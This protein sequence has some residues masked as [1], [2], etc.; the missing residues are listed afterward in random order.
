MSSI[1]S[2]ESSRI[3]TP[4]LADAKPS[5][6]IQQ[7]LFA[8]I[9]VLA[10]RLKSVQEEVSQLATST[11]ASFANTEAL[12]TNHEGHISEVS[13]SLAE[14]KSE[15]EAEQSRLSQHFEEALQQD[16]LVASEAQENIRSQA[17]A[18]SDSLRKLL[19]AEAEKQGTSLRDACDRISKAEKGLVD[20]NG[21]VEALNDR[22]IDMLKGQVLMKSG[23]EKTSAAIVDLNAVTKRLNQEQQQIYSRLASRTEALDSELRS[24]QLDFKVASKR[25]RESNEEFQAANAT[26]AERLGKRLEI[27]EREFHGYTEEQALKDFE[28]DLQHQK[29]QNN[30]EVSSEEQKALLERRLSQVEA[31]GGG[32]IQNLEQELERMTELSDQRNKVMKDNIQDLSDGI[33]SITGNV[34]RIHVEQDS[35]GQRLQSLELRASDLESGQD[36]LKTLAAEAGR[37]IKDIDAREQATAD[38]L[39]ILQDEKRATD[40]QV[41]ESLRAVSDRVQ[42]LENDLESTKQ[43]VAMNTASSKQAHDYF[44]GLSNGVREYHKQFVTEDDVQSLPKMGSALPTLVTTDT[45][46]PASAKSK[47][48]ENAW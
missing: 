27:I 9:D 21:L 39:V 19:E 48:R 15:L 47:P 17:Q 22:Q 13:R 37:G 26:T 30:L 29:T 45:R 11:K 18:E 2:T 16:R 40:Q 28:Q 46:R 4:T 41:Q 34:Q 43:K 36:M 38:N 8:T 14:A 3:P 7:H 24:I 44:S 25:L 20:L 1:A 6:V 23:Y 31:K 35:H 32:R 5:D 42:N 12:L 10:A 33:A